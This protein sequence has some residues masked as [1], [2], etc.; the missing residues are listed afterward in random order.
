M[1]S[2]IRFPSRGSPI[3]QKSLQKSLTRVQEVKKR[4]YAQAAIVDRLNTDWRLSTA[5]ADMETRADI[6]EVRKRARALFRDDPYV[7]GLVRD[8]V[9]GIVG[10][11]GIE[12]H[13][14]NKGTDDKPNVEANKAIKTAW[15]EWGH[16][17]FASTNES[18][19]WIEIQDQVVESFVVDGEV[20]LRKHIGYKNDFGFALEIVDP[21]LLDERLNRNAD[22]SGNQI[23][24]GVEIDKWHRPLFYHFLTRHPA[25][26]GQ[27]TYIKVPANEVIHIFKRKRI[28]Q[29]RGLSNLAPVIFRLHMLGAYEDAE[30]TAARIG[31]SKIGFF[32]TDANHLDAFEP[33]KPNE[34]LTIDVSPGS[35]EQLPPGMKFSGWDPQHPTAAFAAFVA[36]VLRSIA[37]GGGVSYTTLT[38]DLAGV[39]YSSIR[40]GLL[41]ER[42]MFKKLQDWFAE[43]MSRRVFIDWLSMVLLTR[44]LS[45][46]SRLAQNWLAVN[47]K[48]R[49]WKWVDPYNDARANEMNVA[50]GIASRTQL[51]AEMGIDFEETL[52]ELAA[53]KALAEKYDVFI[54]GMAAKLDIP[55]PIP[56]PEQ[57]GG[58]GTPGTT[59]ADSANEPAP[60]KKPQPKAGRSLGLYYDKS[61][62]S[63]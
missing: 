20:L 22:N 49:G 55:Q 1:G 12:C 9:M 36:A 54:D 27:R 16:T 48:G 10:R 8:Y 13:P 7:T 40:A 41:N 44:K 51:C 56:D 26:V 33:T 46:P 23:V 32:E 35:M 6:R 3:L 4:A 24:M 42:D 39:N 61:T 31:A 63:A 62:Q 59:G 45:L 15:E 11:G 58:S 21:D 37:V 5:S 50:M 43:K 53:E 52:I 38:G 30:V 60:A 14:N 57:S 34:K 18:L 19:S 28:G 47:W 29:T 17:E 25:E 2:L